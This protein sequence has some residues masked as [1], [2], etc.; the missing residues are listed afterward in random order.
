VRESTR[1]ADSAVKKLG[2]REEERDR[3]IGE[4][5]T[6]MD[7]IKGLMERVGPLCSALLCSALLCSALLGSQCSVQCSAVSNSKLRLSYV[8]CY[9]AHAL[10]PPDVREA[11]GRPVDLAQRHPGR[12]QVAQVAPRPACRGRLRFCTC[13]CSHVSHRI[14]RTSALVQLCLCR[15]RWL[16]LRHEP[17][18]S[19]FRL[20]CV[21]I[22]V[23][24]TSRRTYPLHRLHLA[25]RGRRPLRP[26]ERRLSIS[27]NLSA[28]CRLAVRERKTITQL[29]SHRKSAA[30]NP[31]VAAAAAAGGTGPG[32]GSSSDSRSGPSRRR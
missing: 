20:I 7:A 29:C 30:G 8:S 6:E 24:P 17:D 5:K 26:R 21:P 25:V 14:R 22:A 11:Q 19:A 3:Q 4:I 1:A 32:S 15:R 9:S 2:E 13:A 28:R 31:S 23:S 10:I 16:R 12:S 18:R 27:I